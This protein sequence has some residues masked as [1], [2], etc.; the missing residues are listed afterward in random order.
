MSGEN[1]VRILV[2]GMIFSP[3]IL[4]AVITGCNTITG[5]IARAELRW[6]H[7]PRPALSARRT[8]PFPH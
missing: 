5:R 3:W 7:H 2:L 6:T 4:L 1:E 8:S